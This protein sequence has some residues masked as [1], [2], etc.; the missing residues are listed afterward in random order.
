MLRNVHLYGSLGDRFG[1]LYRLDV[2]D[3]AEAIRALGAQLPGFYA[4]V[5]E[6]D[7]HVIRG[8]LGDGG[9]ALDLDTLALGLGHETELHFVPAIAGG[10]RRGLIKAVAG[11]ALIGAAVVLSGGAGMSAAAFE[12]AGFE[13]TFQNIAM[14]GLSMALTGVSQMLSPTPQTG[15]YTNRERPEERP[16]FLFDRPVNSSAQ[17]SPVPLVYGRFRVGTRVA[18]A[19]LVAERI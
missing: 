10:K 14:T 3:A 13:V 7:W 1:T 8:P 11:V 4:H 5:R 18:S 6:H 9:R 15:N 12:L 2:R 17:G 19:G 16:S